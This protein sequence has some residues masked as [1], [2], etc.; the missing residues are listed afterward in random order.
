[1]CPVQICGMRLHSLL[2]EERDRKANP[3]QAQNEIP[4]GTPKGPQQGSSQGSFHSMA[5][6]ITA[7]TEKNPILQS[8][9]AWAISPSGE[10]FLARVFL[11]GGS[12]VTLIRRKFSD[13]MGLQGPSTPLQLSVAGG[14]SLPR[15]IEKKVKFQLQSLDGSYISP[16]L[17]GL[18]TAQ[19][20][21]DLRRVDVNTANY[22]HLKGIDFTENYPRPAKEVDILIGV[23]HYTNLLSGEIIRGNPQEPMAIATKLGFVLSG[24]A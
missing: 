20:T 6:A 18:T 3:V 9:Q 7:K 14:Q 13:Q 10:K 17:D 15:T 8:C 16:K 11:D 5:V 22:E 19:I 21:R 2:H 23:E 1:M 24:S 12:E 4:Q